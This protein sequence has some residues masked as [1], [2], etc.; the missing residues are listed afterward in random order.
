MPPP[1][2]PSP[3]L[4]HLLPCKVED[5]VGSSIDIFHANPAHPRRMLA[6]PKNL[7]HRADIKLGPETLNL[8]ISAIY[9]KDKRYDGA[10]V[11]WE[12][13]TDRVRS[14]VENSGLIAAINRAQAVVEFR[15]DGVIV[16]ANEKF[17]TAL[18][19]SL[20]EVKGKHHSIFVE[21]AYRQSAEYTRFLGASLAN[22][23]RISV[24][25]I[26]AHWQ[27]RQ[28]TVYGFKE[29]MATPFSIATGSP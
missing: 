26:Q 6:D 20:E 7:P 25:R 4:A 12:V 14:A 27:R 18:G 22:P 1:L 9:D 17:L 8:T 23:R 15:M 16:D 28:R 19:Y 29:A 2:P 21:E 24:G 13:V 3:G 11:T 10:L 5:V